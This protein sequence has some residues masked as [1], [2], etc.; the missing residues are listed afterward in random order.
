MMSK[1]DQYIHAATREN[2]RI[3]YQSAIRHFEETWEGFLPATADSVTRYLANY[4][5]TLTIST[6]KLR[7]AAL[8]Q[9]HIDQGFPDPTK[10]SMVKKVLKGIKELHPAQVKQAKPL[11][12][13]QLEQLAIWMDERIEKAKAAADHKMLLTQTRNKALVLIGFWRG[14]RSDELS[15]LQAE[16]I[17]LVP[18]EGMT[19]FLPRSKGDRQNLGQEFKVPALSRLCPINAY[20]E[21]ILLTGMRVGPVFFGI[22]R[23]GQI[24]DRALNPNS[25]IMLLKGLFRDA[26]LPDADSFSSHSLRRGFASWASDHQWDIKLL[27]EYVGWRDIKSAMRYIDTSDNLVKNRIERALE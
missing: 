19:I 20:Q 7:L 14:F 2:T 4:A 8:S 25:I 9:W 26:G 27:M 11:K 1:I 3:S 15:R 22:N 17:Q 24:S 5:D 10:A 21:W 12:I 6:L 13:D 16:H 18:G 23:W